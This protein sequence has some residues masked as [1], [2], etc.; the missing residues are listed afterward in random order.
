MC[1][2]HPR[3]TGASP[4]NDPFPAWWYL[5]A[6]LKSSII[7]HH[8]EYAQKDFFSIFQTFLWCT[9]ITV[10]QMYGNRNSCLYSLMYLEM[11][12]MN[13]PNVNNLAFLE[14]YASYDERILE[15]H[16]EE[17]TGARCNNLMSAYFNMIRTLFSVSIKNILEEQFS[18]AQLL[19]DI[20]RSGSDDENEN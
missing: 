8:T 12:L 9:D 16:F 19:L 18:V 3:G 4:V 13:P 2:T 15:K 14:Q 6:I 11:V 20:K 5:C 7:H 10:P 1:P 17:K